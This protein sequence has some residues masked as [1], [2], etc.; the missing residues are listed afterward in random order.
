MPPFQFES[1]VPKISSLPYRANLSKPNEDCPKIWEAYGLT[2]EQF[3][4]INHDANC[5]SLEPGTTICVKEKPHSSTPPTSTTTREPEKKN[6]LESIISDVFGEDRK[7]PEPHAPL[8]YHP[9][10]DFAAD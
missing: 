8:L 3:S 1:S 9:F 2:E 4:L 10:P 5:E 7:V 6:V